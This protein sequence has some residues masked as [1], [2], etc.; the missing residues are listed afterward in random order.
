MNPPRRRAV[1]ESARTVPAS[2]ARCQEP[3]TSQRG[4]RSARP[5]QT[6]RSEGPGATTL[7]RLEALAAAS[8]AVAQLQRLRALAD[9]AASLVPPG[10]TPLVA[11][12]Q[13]LE[14]EEEPLQARFALNGAAAAQAAPQASPADAAPNRTGLPDG[15]KSGL[16]SLSGLAMDQVRVHYNSSKPAEL[17]AHAYAQGTEIH[18]APGQDHHLPHEAWHLVQQAQGRVRPTLQLNGG[19]AVND[20]PLLEREADQMGARALSRGR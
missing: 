2:A 10:Q 20:D 14:E 3:R 1:V 19:V 4:Q 12:R 9:G 7:Q 16:E 18:L 8:P 15:L 6:R 5:P 13:T 11:Q 17:Q